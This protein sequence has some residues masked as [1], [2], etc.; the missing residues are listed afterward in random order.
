MVGLTAGASAPPTL[1][2]DAVA[3]LRRHGPVRVEKRGTVIEDVRFIPPRLTAAGRQAGTASR[4]QGEAQR[5]S[6]ERAQPAMAGG[7]RATQPVASS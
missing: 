6:D 5:G 1:V 2:D 7:W 3:T 4:T